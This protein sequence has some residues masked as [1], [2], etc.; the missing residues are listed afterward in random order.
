MRILL[1]THT[2]LWMERDRDRVAP[3]AREVLDD[4]SHEVWFSAVSSWEIAVKRAKGKLHF[5]GS[6]AAVARRIGL[7]QLAITPEHAEASADLPLHHH[8]PFDRLLIA[9]AQVEGLMLAT[10]DTAMARYGIRILPV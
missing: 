3:S 5:S 2:F 4:P 6:P 8:D 1:D 10:R 9:Q 7:P